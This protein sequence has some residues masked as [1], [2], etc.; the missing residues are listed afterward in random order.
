MLVNIFYFIF[1]WIIQF[2][3]QINIKLIYTKLQEELNKPNA[4][5]QIN[6]E[7]FNTIISC[8]EEA[9]NAIS[10]LINLKTYKF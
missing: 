10:K 6:F 2:G 9:K 4:S 7:L 8:L 1:F 5:G 3:R